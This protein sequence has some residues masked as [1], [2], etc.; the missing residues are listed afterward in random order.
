MSKLP[1]LKPSK[2]LLQT[3]LIQLS[4]IKLLIGFGSLRGA[5]LSPRTAQC[6]PSFLP[7]PCPCSASMNSPNPTLWEKR[8]TK[9]IPPCSPQVHNVPQEQEAVEDSDSRARPPGFPSQPPTTLH[10][11]PNLLGLSS[12]ICEMVDDHSALRPPLWVLA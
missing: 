7:T 2:R 6:S 1:Q 9:G 10:Y 3:R 12:L 8:R 11:V 5:W 4:L